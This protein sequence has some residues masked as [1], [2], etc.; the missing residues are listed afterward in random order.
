[1]RE[2]SVRQQ[3]DQETI[4]RQAAT[5]AQLNIALEKSR[6]EAQQSA[7]A[8]ALDENRTRQQIEDLETRLDDSTRPIRS[9]QAHVTDL[10]EQSR[11]KVDDST[12]SADRTT[13]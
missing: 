2:L 9:L 3:A 11:R 6:Q 12:Q 5:I 8:R 1:M 4:K 10:L 13:S 7:Q